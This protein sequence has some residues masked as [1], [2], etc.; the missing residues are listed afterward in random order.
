MLREMVIKSFT[1]FFGGNHYRIHNIFGLL[2][3][4]KA[5]DERAIQLPEIIDDLFRHVSNPYLLKTVRQIPSNKVIPNDSLFAK[6]LA[7]IFTLLCLRS[8]LL[9]RALS[10]TRFP[11]FN[12]TEEAI[13]FYR[14]MYPNEQKE[15]CLPRS[16]FAA[17]TSKTFTQ[18]GCLFIGVFLP[19]RAMHAWILEAG[20]QPDPYDDIWICY[21]PVAAM[22]SL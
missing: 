4:Y 12:S 9:F 6:I 22:Y 5:Y 19:S 7:R 2:L 21:Q 14:K 13:L 15:L 1:A 3:E 17:C 16:L 18:E 8:F 10:Y 11:I 20:K